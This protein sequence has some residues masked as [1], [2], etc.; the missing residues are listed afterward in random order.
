VIVIKGDQSGTDQV[1]NGQ[2]ARYFKTRPGMRFIPRSGTFSVG[3]AI[4][5]AYRRAALIR[6]AVSSATAA[7]S[8]RTAPVFKLSAAPGVSMSLEEK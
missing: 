3:E 2:S 7:V 8:A 6:A 4:A 1:R 5:A